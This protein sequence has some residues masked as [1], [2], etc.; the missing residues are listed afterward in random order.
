MKKTI[1]ALTLSLSL[2][3]SLVACSLNY[4]KVQA[5]EIKPFTD[6]KSSFWAYT[7]IQELKNKG[8][9]EPLVNNDFA[10]N[11]YITRS[12]AA[13]MI[14]K[15]LGID[16]KSYK[17]V[18]FKD[19]PKSHKDYK[20]IAIAVQEG[21]FN[22][23][24]S[25][26]FEPNGKLTRAQM[27]KVLTLSLDLRTREKFNFADVS[28]NHWAYEY[29]NAL[30][31][32]KI[33]SAPNGKY[34]PNDSVTRAHQAVFLYRTM[35]IPQLPEFMKDTTVFDENI[36]IH[37]PTL[38]HPIMKKILVDGQSVVK[39]NGMK[40]IDAVTGVEAQSQGYKNPKD[41]NFRQVRLS[42]WND[43][44]SFFLTFDFRD[45][46]AVDVATS[47]FQL[48]LPKIDLTESIKTKALEAKN[49]E[50]KGIRWQGN[51]EIIRLGDYR[52]KYGVNNLFRFFNMEVEYVG[53]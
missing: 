40:F 20:Y 25:V 19:V 53:K 5:V 37:I 38:N 15:S 30:Y 16:K 42:E 43:D 21:F 47:W 18:S 36:Q 12:K 24:N 31:Q 41:P 48:L 50:H 35:Q 14:V 11:K 13:R 52:I 32:N 51:A 2:I 9:A 10:P 4:S 6:V 3:G 28:K 7:E 27:A 8:I 44:K 17:N 23:I 34:S 45:D 33:T 49:N 39:K 29:I 22:G 46:R 1:F 26:T